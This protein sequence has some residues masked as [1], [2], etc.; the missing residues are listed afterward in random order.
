VKNKKIIEDRAYSQTNYK[1]ENNV[2]DR[3]ALFN[4]DGEL[5]LSFLG[6]LIDVG[7]R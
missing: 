7:G 3:M 1:I 2:F 4:I 5:K 6:G